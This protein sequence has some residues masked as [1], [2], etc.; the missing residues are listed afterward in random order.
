MGKKG[1]HGRVK[2]HIEQG[3]VHVRFLHY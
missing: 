3:P 1:I 2:G